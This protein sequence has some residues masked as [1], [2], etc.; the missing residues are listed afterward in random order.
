MVDGAARLLISGY[1]GFDNFGDEAILRV[2]TDEWRRRRPADELSVLS[3]RPALTR[4]RYDVAA[5]ARADWRNVRTAVARCDVLVSGGGGLLQ[6]AT[7][8]RSAAYYAGI[9][10]EATRMRRRAAIFAQGIGPL[11]YVGRQIVK[12]FC[13][14][15]GLA[16]VRDSRSRDLLRSILPDLDVRIGADPVFLASATVDPAAATALA[17]EGIRAQAGPIVAIV[18]RRGALLDRSIDRLAA[19]V[20]RLSTRHGAQVVFVP[21]QLPEDAEASTAV[22]RRCKSAPVLLVGGYDL[23]AMTALVAAC[24]AVVSMRLHALI[25]AA[26][27]AVPFLAVPYDPKIGALVDELAYPMQPLARD[28]DGSAAADALW[29]QR[30]QLRDRLALSAPA[31]VE[32]ARRAFDWLEEFVQGRPSAGEQ[33]S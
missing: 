17:N 1:Y 18:P 4:A 12:R 6:T 14:G 24:S 11:N 27:L 32:R 31:L 9:I 19:L 20:D 15:A 7:S 16:V 26:R 5:I 8:I 2:F 29:A 21:L 28:D 25:L 3:A 23:K 13:A 30:S 22:I 33:E 10:R